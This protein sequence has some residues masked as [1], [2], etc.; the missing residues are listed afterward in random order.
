MPHVCPAFR[1]SLSAL[2][3]AALLTSCRGEN[4]PGDT[5][6]AALTSGA[7]SAA[8]TMQSDW[9][10]GY[11]ANV[12]VGNSGA[13]ST[14]G[15][16][17][18]INMNQSALANIWGANQTTAGSSMTTTPLSYDA[19]IAPGA[20]V[21]FGFCGN[22]TGASY[23]PTITSVSA[24]GNG[25]S[26]SG[27]GGTIATGGA[28]A[29]GGTTGTGGVKATGGTTG[30]GGSIATGG[31]TGTG[32]AKTCGG[33]SAQSGDVTINLSDVHQKISGFGASTAW[34]STMSAADAATLWSTTTGA[35]LSLHRVRIDPST[36]QTSETNIAKQA[37]GYGVK[38]WATPWTPPAADKSNNNTVMGTLTNPSAFATYLANFV[39]YMKGQGVPIYAV[40]AQNEP[41][42]NVTYES[43]TYTPSS[44]TQW[45][46][47]Y[48]G[49]KLQPM[50]VKVMAP[51][52]Q[53]WCG[54]PSFES[55]LMS[56]ANAVKYTDIVA[57][58]EYGCSPSA[59]PAIAQAGKEFWE[60]EIYD[61]STS[62]ADTGMGSGL[63][64][65]KLIHD[66]LTVASMNAWHYWWVY[67]AGTDNQALWDKATNGP[68]KRLWVEG[69]YA[70]FVRPGFQRVGATG[71]APA[72][73]LVSAYSNPA[74]GTVA[75]V[76]INNNSGA[77]PLS[78]FVSGAA[79]CALTPWV[80]SSSDSLASKSAVSVSGSRVTFTLPAQSVT[81]LVGKP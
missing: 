61:T 9:T 45:V 30:T 44:M 8:I 68:T 49:P 48:L 38:V 27:S 77:T 57:T 26:A 42:A 40:S 21:T 14:T 4:E 23:H 59:Y 54:F 69:N 56:D 16:T 29:T 17:V 67:P 53:N 60:T 19:V 3:V 13:S 37:V 35:G 11:C 10:A 24:T 79:P 74:D 52:T 28:T 47:A 12:T 66:A 65:A 70:R 78:L 32:G 43:C 25:G 34:G 41:D 36:G 22:A 6:V 58:H 1:F 71:T 55:A 15:W 39:T 50:G 81:T 51:E 31:T 73:V 76:A 33:G 64:V 46:G 63:R 2:L 18:V 75:V 5:V 80:T 7:T 62:T 20:S 72:G